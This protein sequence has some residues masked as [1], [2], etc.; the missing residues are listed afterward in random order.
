[1]RWTASSFYDGLV[2]TGLMPTI[3][4]LWLK[5][6]HF[7]PIGRTTKEGSADGRNLFDPKDS[8]ETRPLNPGDK[9]AHTKDIRSEWGLI[10]HADL[11]AICKMIL[12]F[13]AEMAGVMGSSFRSKTSFCSRL[14]SQRIRE[15]LAQL[16]I[17]LGYGR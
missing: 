7:T 3:F 11:A 2:G 10:T 13:E 1:M 17:S 9:E 16:G 14:I 8:R 15:L 12:N 6:F 4:R 5:L